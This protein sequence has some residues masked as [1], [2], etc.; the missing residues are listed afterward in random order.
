MARR[1]DSSRVHQMASECFAMR[2]RTLDRV[3]TNLYDT[4]LRPLD[5]KV[6]QLDILVVVCQLGV[7]RPC[8]ICEILRMD[9]ST[10][11]RNADRLVSRGWLETVQ[12]GDARAQPLRLTRQGQ[13]VIDAAFPAWE[14]A[15]LEVSELLGSTGAAALLKAAARV[16]FSKEILKESPRA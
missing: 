9:T 8:D 2:I 14:R 13:K 7:A 1:P 3:I 15:Q 11:S 6:T 5:L 12:T 16:G 10:L 4:A